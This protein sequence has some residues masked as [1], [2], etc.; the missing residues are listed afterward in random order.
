MRGN[1]SLDGKDSQQRNADHN[2][3]QRRPRKIRGRRTAVGAASTDT[4]TVR[5][6][7][8]RATTVRTA[9]MRTASMRTASI[10]AARLA[11]RYRPRRRFLATALF[12][13]SRFH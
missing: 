12:L 9:S 8:V 4:A 13:I 3:G 10:P 7:T 1:K 2:R 6:T 5:A 11:S